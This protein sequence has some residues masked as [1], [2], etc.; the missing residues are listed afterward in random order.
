LKL[1]SCDIRCSVVAEFDVRAA[2]RT[3]VVW[4]WTVVGLTVGDVIVGAVVV[5]IALMASRARR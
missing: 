4:M 5:L 2:V 3:K 1:L